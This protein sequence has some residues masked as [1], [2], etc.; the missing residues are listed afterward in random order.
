MIRR[1]VQPLSQLVVMDAFIL[2]IGATLLGR[3]LAR[4]LR[5]MSEVA[6]DF[7]A[8]KL[9]AR[10]NLARED[11][12]G[13][14]AAAFDRMADRLTDLLRLEMELLANISH[15]LRTPLTRIR[16]ALEFA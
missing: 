8:G 16:L 9:R 13:D 3:S 11:E 14:V 5:R 12:I 7:G 10:V 1:P 15:E 2:V 6:H 4:P